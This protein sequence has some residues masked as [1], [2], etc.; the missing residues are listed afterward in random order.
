MWP[1]AVVASLACTEK[2]NKAAKQ[3]IFS[4]EEPAADVQLANEPISVSS[5]ASDPAV[6]A[7]LWRMDRREVTHRIGAHRASAKVNFKW[8]R[9]EHVVALAE[10]YQFETDTE[11]QFHAVI[12]N[13]QDSGLEFVWVGGKAFAKRRYG[14]YRTHLT[15]REQQDQWRDEATS[16]LR[17]AFDL[18]DRRLRPTAGG[19]VTNHGR[20]LQHFGLTLGEPWGPAEKTK[21]QP[22]PVYGFFRPAGKEGLEPGPDP[23]TA[24]RAEMDKRV[25][26][27]ATGSIDV[28]VNAAV[29]MKGNLKGKFHV[30]APNGQVGATLELDISYEL[31]PAATIAIAPPDNVVQARLPHV[32]NDP[33]WFMGGT[34]AK[35]V[36]DEDRGKTPD[37]AP[38]DDEPAAP[39]KRGK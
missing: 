31:T 34:A 19:A 9:G 26:D 16:A 14:A 5:A 27:T 8:V 13:D 11:G 2:V 32:V 39:A 35:D 4:P 17:T 36:D 20:E 24:K 30:P 37:E 15:D 18:Y 38:A 25:P 29:V 3:R 10:E 21:D 28:D 33:L 1:V 6:W 23:D 7:R 12:T 22:K